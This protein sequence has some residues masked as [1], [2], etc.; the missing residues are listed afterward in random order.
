MTQRIVSITISLICA[1][2]ILS[3]QVDVPVQALWVGQIWTCDLRTIS[4]WEEHTNLKWTI[5]DEC[6]D[7]LAI[8]PNGET[9]AVK[10]KKYFTGTLSVLSSWVYIPF[11]EI[12]PD[13]QDQ[14]NL[15]WYFSC[16]DNPVTVTP[17]SMSLQV[18]QQQRLSYSH[19]NNTYASAANV[20]FTCS[21]SNIVTVSNTGMITAKKAG[22]AKVTVHSNLANDANAPSCFVTV[23]P[24]ESAEPVSITIPH[25]VALNVGGE[26][27]LTPIV[28]PSGAVYTV[29]WTSS[30]TSV[31]AVSSSGKVL[32]KKQG[33]AT[34][35]ARI[36]G[37]NLVD[38]CTVTVSQVLLGDVNDDGSV[39]IADVTS[40]IDLLLNGSSFYDA[41][42]DMNQ[43]GSVNI[44]DV[45]A[46]IDYLLNGSGKKGD[47]NND[48]Q[49]N[50]A[51]VTV[52]I[53]YLLNGSMPI[54]KQNADMNSDGK[55]NIADVTA[56]IDFLLNGKALDIKLVEN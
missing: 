17:T 40:L 42:A 26:M 33:T 53:D 6:K 24:A 28:T 1:C 4:T 15:S 30:N 41:A 8:T 31:A 12:L 9:C 34:I 27:T 22:T 25:Q 18:G 3:A 48:G 5:A 23:I 43:D 46:L 47:V 45:T 38:Y 32:A 56:L 51:D 35:T 37:T 14:Y 10:V 44:A 52:L 54:N 20:S 19:Y 16:I 49:V 13:Y 11:P 55:I 7:Y 29:N 50:I 2:S 36:D 21:P 39:N